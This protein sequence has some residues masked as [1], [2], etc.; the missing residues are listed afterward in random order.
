MSHTST[1]SSHLQKDVILDVH[2]DQIKSMKK[3][4][5][6]G[7]EGI[8]CKTEKTVG[9]CMDLFS[10]ELPVYTAH[11]PSETL[12]GLED[13]L[14]DVNLRRDALESELRAA[15]KA[16]LWKRRYLIITT[17]RNENQ[18]YRQAAEKFRR[19][20]LTASD[21]ARRK[22]RYSECDVAIVHS[23]DLKLRHTVTKNH[24]NHTEAEAGNNRPGVV[25]MGPDGTS[26]TVFDLA[27][28]WDN[29]R[30]TYLD[31]SGNALS[32]PLDV[33]NGLLQPPDGALGQAATAMGTDIGRV[34]DNVSRP[35][36]EARFT[37]GG[38]TRDSENESDA[39]SISGAEI[40]VSSDT[41]TYSS[42]MT[43]AD[44]DAPSPYQSE[45]ETIGEAL[46]S[47]TPL[48]DDGREYPTS[49]LPTSPR[50]VDS[51]VKRWLG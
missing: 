29:K 32:N 31:S 4:T 44:R 11:L 23:E 8:Y 19:R 34:V 10:Q 46:R 25:V 49:P 45:F 17:A 20:L 51:I 47:P 9:Q 38:S 2:A 43:P 18:A 7:F 6:W 37:Q 21:F 35:E 26:P 48:D 33:I 50:I 41:A 30:E 5:P 16:P 3:L 36:D 12:R 39:E 27:A 15:R 22:K 13:M 24:G 28:P 14:D 42:S 40:T 1:P